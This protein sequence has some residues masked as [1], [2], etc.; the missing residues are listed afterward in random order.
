MG[1]AS[2]T[3]LDDAVENFERSKVATHNPQKPT[4]RALA[5]TKVLIG[6]VGYSSLS[7]FFA[8]VKRCGKSRRSVALLHF[9]YSSGW[10]IEID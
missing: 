9:P 7:R 4:V 10:C 3:R 5:A 6:F 8:C 2:C 1:N